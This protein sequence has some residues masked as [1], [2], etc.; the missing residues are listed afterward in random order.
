MHWI[1]AIAIKLGAWSALRKE[2]K[3]RKIRRE[4][5]A[6]DEDA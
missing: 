1:T 2:L 3:R 4:N 5:I 6:W